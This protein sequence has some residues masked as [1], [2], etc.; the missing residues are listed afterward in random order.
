MPLGRAKDRRDGALSGRQAPVSRRQK[1]RR[2]SLP[3][4]PR[5]NQQADPR[6][7]ATDHDHR[8]LL[9]V[10][11]AS[12]SDAVVTTDAAG[13]VTL[14]NPIAESLTGWTMAEATGRPLEA[15]FQIIDEDGRQPIEN[16]AVRA[17]REGAVAGLANHSLLLTR[18]GREL[19]VADSAAPICDAH[20]TVSGAVVVFKDVSERR[21]LERAAAAARAFA[22]N[23]V[24]TVREPLLVLGADLKVQ[25]ANRSFYRTFRVT[26]QDTE[27][28]FLYELGDGQWNIPALRTL[29]E[30][31]LPRNT[32]FDDFEVEHTFPAL[33]RRTMLL[34]ARRIFF[35]EGDRTEIILLAIEDN[36]ERK[37][38]ARAVE[39]SEVRYRRLFETAQDAI[40]I[41]DADAGTIFDANPF[42]VA[43]LGYS[44]EELIGKELWEIGL[45]RDREASRTA[46]RELQEHGYIR[47]ENLPLET[48]GGARKD[49]EFVSNVYSVGRQRVIQCNIRDITD[50]KRS[51]DALKEADHRKD[52]F[53]AM[54]AHEL[55]NPLAPIRSALQMMQLKGTD[56]ADVRRAHEVIGRHVLHL[57]RLVDDLLDVA[58]ITRGKVT[59]LMEP[60]DLAAVVVQ[61]VEIS[62]PLIDA[63][64]HQLDVTLPTSAVWVEA[65]RTRLAQV[66]SNLLNNAAKYT[67]EGGR[68]GLTWERAGDQAVLRVRDEGV[69]IAAEMLPRVFDLFTQVRGSVSRSDG[70]LGIGLTLARSLVEMHGG[71]VQALSPGLGRGSEFA[72][73]LP[74]LREPSAPASDAA[75]EPSN[76]RPVS[77]RLILL[78][79]DN[80]DAAEML[81]M[82]LRLKGHEV[83]TAYDGPTALDAVRARAPDVVLCDIGMPGMDGLQVARCMREDFGLKQTLLVALTGYG[84]DDDRRRTQ[85]AGFNAHL[86]KPV[87][88]NE[89]Q[90][91]LTRRAL[92]VAD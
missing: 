31:V 17:L 66:V 87:D 40:L 44:H 22:E 45:F 60:I 47:Y 32:S 62:R 61:A 79:D 59:L 80:G 54:L 75:D 67:E 43:M 64:K 8:E 25:M 39:T 2:P 37:R 49:V 73:Y 1:M 34:N 81:A 6:P 82:L 28:R 24:A 3:E 4:P 71:W 69:G 18:D 58:R 90:D 48:K 29:L 5:L 76:V 42:L 16:P 10:T 84:Q 7:E 51:E 23:V 56:D 63:R 15:V 27:S 89:L 55:R 33:G 65:D 13:R 72:I 77:P 91:L 12:I 21:R 83:R 9:R 68:I 11:L 19:P 86:V 14:M 30:E 88:L 57:V 35:G 52:E 70:G 46:V 50:R 36:T 53:L 20:G 38:T 74:R 92:L 41:L 85:E 26:P 78:V